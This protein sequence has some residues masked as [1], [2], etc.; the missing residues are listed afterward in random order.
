MKKKE[1]FF[2][3][4]LALGAASCAHS[5]H[6]RGTVA[7]VHSKTEADVCIGS[8]EVK[9]GDPVSIYKSVCKRRNPSDV[10]PSRSTMVSCKKVKLGGA[11]VS[12][13]LDEHYSTIEVSDGT[14]LAEGLIIEKITKP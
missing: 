4:V 2:G 11:K 5:G 6:N 3:L 13:V 7:I 9:E 12:R 8:T 14:P 10:H 1:L